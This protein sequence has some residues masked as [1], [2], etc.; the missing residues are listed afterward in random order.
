MPVRIEA[1]A[2]PIPGYRLIERLGGGG[3]GEVWKAEAPGGLFKAIKFVYGDLH[4]S[5]EDSSRAGQE[6]K[7]LSRV[8]TVHH[9]YILSLERYDIID[10]QLIIVMELADRTLWDRFRECQNQG[11]C[12]I[13]RT[14]LLGYLEETAEALDLMNSQF[15][16]QHLDIKPQNLFLVFNHVKVADF[17]LVKDLEGRAATV[18]GGVT[19]VYAAP[20]T[21][22]GWVSRFS[23]QYSLAIVYQELLTGKRPFSG[24]TIR[25]LVLQHLQGAPD[26]SSLL[27]AERGVIGRALSKNPDHRYPTCKEFIVALRGAAQANPLSATAALP[28]LDG[29]QKLPD[30]PSAGSQAPEDLQQT[31]NARGQTPLKR[32]PPPPPTPPPKEEVSSLKPLTSLPPRPPKREKPRLPARP[33]TP[34]TPGNLD[35]TEMPLA[36]AP[37]KQ[38]AAKPQVAAKQQQAEASETGI[39]RPAL[40]L[41]LGQLGLSTL[42]LLRKDINEQFKDPA[43][44]PQLR[45]L[46]LDTDPDGVQNIAPE[47]PHGLQPGEVM[48]TRL[49]RAVHYLKPREGKLPYADWLNSKLLY[50]IPR[51][52]THAGLRALGRLAYIDNYRPIHQRLEAALATCS[53][54]ESLQHAAN[55][56]QLEVRTPVPRVYVITGLAGCTGSG[57]FLDL[58]YGVRSLLREQGFEN[59][60]IVGLFLVPAATADARSTDLAHTFAAFTEL[61]HYASPKVAFTARYEQRDTDKPFQESGPPFQQCLLLPLP[62]PRPGSKPSDVLET[63]EAVSSYIFYDLLTPMGRTIDQARRQLACERPGPFYSAIPYHTFGLHR[64]TWPRRHILNHTA[65]HLCGRLVQHWMNKNSRPIQ[66]EVKRWCLEQWEGLGFRPEN[67]IASHQ[68]KCAQVLKQAPETMFQGILGTL[69]AATATPAGNT[70]AASAWTPIVQALDQVERLLGVPPECRDDALA[71]GSDLEEAG[72]IE[73]ALQECAEPI[74]DEIEQKLAEL[75]VRLFEEPPF[76]LAGAEEAVRQFGNCIQTA[77]ESQETLLQELQARTVAVHQRLHAL[78]EHNNSPNSGSTTTPRW[79]SPFTRRANGSTSAAELPELVR[80]FTKCRYQSLILQSVGALYLRLRGYLSDQMREI[81][82]CRHRLSELADLIKASRASSLSLCEASNQVLLPPG[83]ATVEDAVRQLQ[84]GISP[85]DL[86]AF[87][88][89]AQAL[90]R[91]EFRALV[92]VCMATSTVIRTLAPL[93]VDEAEKFLQ[94]RV[95]SAS[96]AELLLQRYLD[97]DDAEARLESDLQEA[98]DEAAPELL[99][100]SPDKEMCIIAIPAGEAGEHLRATAKKLFPRAIL[101]TSERTDEILIYRGFEQLDLADLQQ[102]GPAAQDAYRKRHAKDPTILHTRADIPEWRPVVVNSTAMAT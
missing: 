99:T 18:T 94:P 48:L 15:Q 80:S 41:G 30:R 61:N 100:A 54:G 2:E 67:L 26:L 102:L 43:C 22:D 14:E 57:M 49:H 20:E 75:V 38:Q 10:G 87:D 56:T 12:G 3:F 21:F 19:P 47:R 51:Q 89:Q 5:D 11:L 24:T 29:R 46:Y 82:Y 40:V 68:E 64:I 95:D 32:Q 96:V 66:E 35:S 79:K 76:R 70:L 17:G 36:P 93:L 86:L 6:L 83:C 31:Q 58:A 72:V 53:A 85:E 81:G 7:A 50:H 23:D 16:L 98:V 101:V 45:L 63:L 33:V 28:S 84:T 60:E 34:E 13:P 78:L 73:K 90:V 62:E 74:A 37:P 42:K 1:Q 8:K 4:A 91:K 39:L 55:Y 9:P 97:D 52:Q 77:L 44:L 65:Y 59:A 69:P 88:Q 25:Q 71:R 92:H 27:L